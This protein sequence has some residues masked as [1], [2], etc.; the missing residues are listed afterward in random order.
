MLTTLE[1]LDLSN[2][3]L[4][5]DTLHRGAANILK[6]MSGKKAEEVTTWLYAAALSR[7]PTQAEREMADGLLGESPNAE[8]LEDLLWITI[9]LPEYQI[10]R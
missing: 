1:A 9:M 5:A 7:E 10:I 2:S 8:G 3:V 4:L 6:E